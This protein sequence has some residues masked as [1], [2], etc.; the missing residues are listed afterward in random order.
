MKN[1]NDTL[2]KTLEEK[3]T[4]YLN[5][6]FTLSEWAGCIRMQLLNTKITR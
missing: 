6:K 5:T 4:E 1:I 3:A 2:Q